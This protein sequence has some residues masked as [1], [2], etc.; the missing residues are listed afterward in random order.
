MVNNVTV[1]EVRARECKVHLDQGFEREESVEMFDYSNILLCLFKF[2]SD[3]FLKTKIGLQNEPKM[4][5]F[6]DSFYW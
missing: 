5:L 3:L 4:L 1:V 6:S 2:F